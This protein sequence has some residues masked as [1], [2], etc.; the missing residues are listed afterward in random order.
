MGALWVAC[1]S[2]DEPGSLPGAQAGQLAGPSDPPFIPVS[3]NSSP[4]AAPAWSFTEAAQQ[5]T[6][7]AVTSLVSLTLSKEA[8]P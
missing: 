4:Q 2:P 1:G 3:L 7:V 8:I 5:E 6:G